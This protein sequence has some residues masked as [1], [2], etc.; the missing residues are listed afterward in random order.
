LVS[1][2][3]LF[4]A[5]AGCL[6]LASGAAAATP[7]V[8]ITQKP[9]NP[10]RDRSPTFAFTASEQVT[11]A[12]RLDGAAFASCAPGVSYGDLADGPHTFVVRATNA[13]TETG[14][15]S[16]DWTID[17]RPPVANV[18]AAPVAMSNSP[19]A[20]FAFSA[21]EPSSFACRLDD[22]DFEPCSS[23]VSYPGLGDGP[24]TF[25]VRPTDAAGNIG[26]LSWHMWTVD[27]TAP[28]T[29]L[30]ARPRT[31]TATSATFTFSGSELGGFECRLGAAAF[32][33]CGSPKRYARLKRG[34]HSFEV[35][36]LDI[37]GNRDATPAVHRWKITAAPRKAKATSALLSPQLGARVT[38]P[39]LLAWRRVARASYYNVQLYRGRVKVLSAWPTRPRLQLRK[40]WRYLG[41]RRTLSRGVYRWY[42]W[43]GFGAASKNRYGA[44]LGE[45]TF[46]VL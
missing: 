2:R 31:G 11:W 24:H 42:V 34:S 44:L 22:R 36:A 1:R 21:D 28:D 33:P 4:I 39:P 46:T 6:L 20:S 41:R 8:T 40:R 43:P 29:T 7:T 5:A 19:S 15:E 30:A 45:S 27:A 38:A 12:C 17:V 37:A 14:E 18:I 9:S 26:E 3:F 25:A 35:R 32:A 23:P 13:G 16:Y 10:S